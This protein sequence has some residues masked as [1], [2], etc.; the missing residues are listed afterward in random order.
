MLLYDCGI[1]NLCMCTDVRTDDGWM[2]K[3]V[4]LGDRVHIIEELQLFKE[5]Q[6]I[7]TMVISYKQ[8]R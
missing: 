1:L 6:P 3:A 8:V 7:N 5:P 4:Q 2:H